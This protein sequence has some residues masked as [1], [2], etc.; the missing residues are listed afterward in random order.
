MILYVGIFSESVGVCE[1]V[2]VYVRICGYRGNCCEVI[3]EGYIGVDRF[4][5]DIDGIENYFGRYGCFLK[6]YLYDGFFYIKVNVDIGVLGD[7]S[8]IYRIDKK[9]F[10]DYIYDVIR[11]NVR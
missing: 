7:F 6:V 9:V 1:M 11:K 10:C 2:E 3:G 8:G 5:I 4:S